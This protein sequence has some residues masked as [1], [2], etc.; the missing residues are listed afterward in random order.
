MMGTTMINVDWGNVRAEDPQLPITRENVL[1]RI[2]ENFVE[3][4]ILLPGE[5]SEYRDSFSRY[6]WNE[7]LQILDE[8][9]RQRVSCDLVIT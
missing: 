7:L 8:S 4:G 1:V 9:N 5:T 3:T 6:N 2:M